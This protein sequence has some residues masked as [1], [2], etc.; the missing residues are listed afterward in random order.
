MERA[1]NLQKVLYFSTSLV[2]TYIILGTYEWVLNTGYE[3]T[4]ENVNCKV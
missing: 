4:A 2:N 1:G 3:R